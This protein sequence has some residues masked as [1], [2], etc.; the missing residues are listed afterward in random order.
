M[1]DDN[2]DIDIENTIIFRPGLYKSQNRKDE[3]P[4]PFFVDDICSLETE[5][6]LK[7]VKRE[8]MHMP[9]VGFCGDTNSVYAGQE[10]RNKI[11]AK[12]IESRWCRTNFILR[13][14][15]YYKQMDEMKKLMRKEYIENLQESEFCLSVRGAG[16]YSIRFY[17]ICCLG[18]IPVFI[19]TDC[20]LPFDNLISYRNL[21]LWIE[22]GEFDYAGEKVNCL[23][24]SLSDEEYQKRSLAIRNIWVNYFS[25]NG[26]FNHMGKY[27]QLS[28]TI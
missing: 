8:N 23:N 26:F 14:R 7:I 24:R 28:K 4:C 17:E 22:A 18:K 5:N 3:Y 25:L 20:W 19:N 10:V 15:F 6:K 21:F 2:D 11:L 16:N 12:L 13:T 1:N 9:I 27:L